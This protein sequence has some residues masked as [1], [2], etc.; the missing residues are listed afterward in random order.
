MTARGV[1]RIATRGSQLALWQ[2]H[3][4]SDRLR[5]V[6]AHTEIVV[7]TTTGDRSQ[8]APVT[9]DNSK[10]QFVKELE[11]ALLR[12]DAD[13]AVHSAKDLP[14]VLP[15]GLTVAACL[16]REDPRDGIVL[17]SPGEH[18]A[19]P[20]ALARLGQGAIIGTGSVRRI[21]QL[22]PLVPQ[23]T[24]V[25]VRGNV[26]TRLAKLDRGG[27]DALVL[28]C[29]GLRRLG[30]GDRISAAIPVDQCVPAPGQGIVAIEIRIDFEAWAMLQ[31]IH[32]EASGKALAAE[33]ALVAT[34]GGGC[35]LPLGAMASKHD[36]MLE[37]LAIVASLDGTRAVRR[38]MS[39]PASDPE[40]LGR[41]LADALEREGARELLDQVR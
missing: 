15:E 11:D 19:V 25:P 24:F 4:V 36:G 5:A 32:D 3:A 16:A 21:A 40:A 37:M 9:G 38:S 23:A 13:L 8:R 7:I 31:T 6:G 41:R 10:R 29:A 17:P 20:D 2:A 18:L 39:G 33:R 28:A 14:S 27:F 1:F 34:L 30:F 12:G 26:D 22:A 35:Q